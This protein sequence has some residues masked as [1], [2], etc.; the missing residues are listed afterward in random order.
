MTAR[1]DVASAENNVQCAANS[2]YLM[3][4]VKPQQF[5]TVI[6]EIRDVIT[7]EQIIISIAP[8]ITTANLKDRFGKKCRVVRAMPNTPALVGDDRSV[9]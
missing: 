9:L 2:K 3:L 4:A 1:T 5:D 8:G 7:E 6:G